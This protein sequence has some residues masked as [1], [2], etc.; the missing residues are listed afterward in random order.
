MK[1]TRISIILLFIA[2]SYCA[3]FHTS[4]NKQGTHKKEIV[5]GVTTETTVVNLLGMP[6]S[7]TPNHIGDEVWNYKNLSY[8]TDKSNERNTLILWEITTGDSTEVS[9]PFD[10]LITFDQNDIVKDFELVLSPFDSK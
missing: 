2:N 6:A 10:L 8:S 7:V 5:K 9:K 1:I 4:Q 3:F